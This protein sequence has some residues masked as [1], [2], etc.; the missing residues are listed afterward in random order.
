MKMKHNT[1]I[2]VSLAILGMILISMWLNPLIFTRLRLGIGVVATLVLGLLY[3]VYRKKQR[4]VKLHIVSVVLALVFSGVNGW[5][6]QTVNFIL[7]NERK[8]VTQLNVY[9]LKENTH[10]VV[11]P[12]LAIGVS[13]NINTIARS[14]FIEHVTSRYNFALIPRAEAADGELM[15]LLYNRRVEAIVLD[16]AVLDLLGETTKEAFLA[17]TEVIYTFEIANEQLSNPI[18]DDVKTDAIVM[19]ISG[20]DGAGPL[21]LR[22]RSDVNQLV[23]IN[24]ATRIISLVSIPRDT[25]VPTPCINDQYDKLSHAGVRGV[26]CSITTLENYL[27]VPIDYYV[28]LNFNSFLSIL[29]IIGPIEVYSHYSFVVG[30]FRYVAGMNTM[31]KDKALAFARA[32]KEL[33]G[34]DQTRGL[35]QQ[36]VIR[37]VF[38][39]VM[40]PAQ[41]ANLQSLLHATRRFV[42]TNVRPSSVTTL[43]DMHLASSQPW[44]LDS[45]VLEG[46]VGWAPNPLNPQ[47]QFSVVF[48]SPSQ[49]ETYRELIRSLRTIPTP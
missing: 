23:I 46:Q 47:S 36:E 31:D 20:G 26:E 18:V 11:N 24:P 48:H 33:P 43:L 2:G 32:R 25:L 27:Q 13:S 4:V 3:I 29:D 34:G 30:D 21:H 5:F 17:A 40:S 7:N 49:L 14:A 44:T 35:H 16:V 41:F 38:N 37:G 22:Q 15:A 45:H 9:V 12:N 42:E 39:R 1:Y 28:R 8:D 19:Y 10:L 6:G